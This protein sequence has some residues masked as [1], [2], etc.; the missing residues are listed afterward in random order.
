MPMRPRAEGTV[1]KIARPG[2]PRWLEASAIIV[3]LLGATAAHAQY[4]TRFSTITNGAVSFTGNTLGLSKASNLNQP[5]TQDAIGA[6]TTTNTALQVGTFPP[7]TTLA[8]AQNSSSATLNLPA[9]S[10]VLYAELTW[11]GSYGLGGQDVSGSRNNPITL[12]TPAG[13]ST[14]TPDPAF[15]RQLG[16]P[17]TGAG[18]TSNCFYV[19]T[20]NVTSLIQAGGTGTYTVGGVP[21]TVGA[22]DNTNNSAGW[23]LAVVYQDFSKPVRNLALFVGSELSGAPAASTSG[24]CTPPAGKLSGR[25]AVS[26]MEGDANKTNDTMLFGPATPLGT[27][28]QLKGPN[29]PQTNFFASQVNRDDGTLDTGGT[30]GTRNA[31][32]FTSSLTSGGRQGWDITNVDVS[33]QLR[34]GQTQAFAQGTTSGDTY[35]ISA[36]GLQIDVGAPVFPQAKSVDKATTF[37]GD[38]LTYTTTVSNTGIVDATN[39]VFTDPP[40]PGTTFIAGSFKV[41]GVVQPG[42]NPGAG[43]NLGTVAGGGSKTVQFQVR[44]N[45]IP[46]SPAPAQYDATASFTYQYVSCAGQP[47]QN[48]TFTT[49]TVTTL[50]PRIEAAKTA[51]PT[52]AVPGA[53]LEYAV[54]IQNTGTA[55]ATGVTL[56]DPIPAGTTYIPGSTTLNAVAIPDVGGMMPFALGALINDSGDPPGVI[57]AS[58]SA[59]LVFQV[60][61]DPSATM[62]ITNTATID[63]DGPGSLQPFP[64]AVISPVAAMADVTVAKDG[65]DRAVAGTNVTFTITVTNDGPSVATNVVLADPTPP[66]LGFVSNSGACT[67]AFPCALGTLAP[68]ATR[69]VTTTFSVPGTYTT[70]DPIVNLASVTS[71]TPDPATGNNAAQASV[72]VAAPV[73][74]LT[75]TKTD[76]TSSAVPGN[77]T[78]YTITVGNTG[79]SAVTGVRVTDPVTPELSGFIWTCSGSGGASCAA[80][81]GSGALD[82][83]V[84]LPVGTS[85]TFLLTAT[86]AADA[87]EAVSNT[88]TAA[89]PPGVGGTSQVAD[90]DTDQVNGLADL[91]V[92]KTGPLTAAVPGTNVVYTLVVRNAGPSTARDASVND[93]TPAGLN[94][95][96]TSGDCNTAFPC[97]FGTLLP[98]ETRTIT[99][100][101]EVPLGYTSPNPIVNTASVFDTTTDPNPGNRSTSA[102]TP[103]DLNADVAVLKSVAPTSALVGD[104]VTLFV[105]VLNNGPNQASGVVITDVLPAGMTFVSA[106]PQQGSYVPSSGQ[107]QVGDLQN[108]ANATLTMTAVLT[109][110][111]TITNTATK[112]SANEP[113]PDTSNDSAVATLNAAAAADVAIQKA[114]DN[115]TP[116][117]GQI[118][119]FVVTA[120]NNGPSNASGITVTDA[121]PA[122][123]ALVASTPSQGTYDA[124]TGAWTVG[125]IPFPGS[126]T[127]T[128]LASVNTPGMIVNTANKTQTEADPNPANDESSVSLNAGT[129]ADIRV[130]KAISNP[131]P[132]VD[133]QVTFTVTATNLGPSPATGVLITDQLPA[134]LTFVSATPSQ[135]TYDPASG[136]WTAGSIAASQSAVLSITALVAQ[137]GPFTNT[138]IKTSASEEDP[139]PGN[140]SGSVTATAGRVADLS[141]TK[142]DGLDTVVAGAMEIYTITVANAGP[143]TVTGASVSDTFPV[144]LTGVTWTCSATDGG[145]CGTASGDGPIATTV[146]LPAGAAAIFT[147]TV[148]V[149]PDAIGALANSASVTPPAGTTDPTPGD[150]T[151]TDTT[152]ITPSADVQVSKTAS[153]GSV[154]AGDDITFT[155]VVTNIGPS[156]AV[157]VVV[158]DPTPTGLTFTSNGDACTTVFPCTLG[159]LAPGASATI[160]SLFHIPGNYAGP[161]PIENTATASSATPDPVPAN[162]AGSASASLSDRQATLTVTK[163]DGTASVVP[164]NPT[165]YTITVTNSGPSDASGVSVQDQVTVLS[166]A[167]WTCSATGGGSCTTPTG[168]GSIDTTVN[169]PANTAATFVLTGTVPADATGTLTNTAEAMPPAGFANPGSGVATDTDELTPQADLALTKSGPPTVVPGN[170]AVYTIVV[171]NEGPSTATN[172]VVNDSTP[173]GLTFVSNSGDCTTPFPCTLATL[174]PRASRTITTTLLVPP[175]YQTPNPI[176]Q[177]A[178]V[179][180]QTPD[181]VPGNDSASVQ[182]PVDANADVEVTK[183]VAPATGILVGDSVSFT[184]QARNNGPNAATGVVVTDL[185]PAGLS[186]VSASPTQGAYTDSSGEWVISAL[187]AGQSVEL[188]IQAQ[189]TQPGDITNLAIRTGGNEPDPNPGNE[190]GAATINVAAAADVAVQKTADKTTPSVGE[191]VTF[192]VTATNR[193]PSDAT[194]V[195][196]QDALPAGLALTS[197]A[198]SQGTYDAASGIWTVG[199]LTASTS[200]T[201][202]VV[203]SVNTTGTLVNVA[204]KTGQTEI[205]PNP[206]NDQA[207]LSLNAAATADIDVGKTI[208]TASPAVGGQVSFTVTAT[209]HGPSPATGVVVTDLLP[210]G[211]A[212]VSAPASQGTYD[213]DSGTWTVGNLPATRSAILSITARV[214]R[215]GSFTNTASR[216]AGN[217]ID[218]NP[219]NDASSVPGT[220]ALVADL[221]ITKTDGQT[222]ALPGAPLTYT[223]TVQNAG[224]SDVAGAPVG[225]TFPGPLTGASWS[226]SATPG[227][228]CGTPGGTGA[229]ATTVDLPAGGG[230]TFIATATVP[231]D[232][233]GAVTNTA[234]V[235]APTGTVDPD[236]T[237]DDATDSTDLTSSAN[238]GVTKAGPASAFPGERVSYT[239]VVSNAGASTA[240]DVV[241]TDPTPPGLAF[242]SNGGDC[243]T[244]FP[245]ALG[246]IAPSGSRTIVATYTVLPEATEVVNSATV[247]S[248]TPDPDASD[249]TGSVTTEVGLVS[250]PP[251]TDADLEVSKTGTPTSAASGTQV[252]Y[253]LRVVNHGP[254]SASNVLLTDTLPAGVQLVSATASAGACTGGN[255]I[256]CTVASLASGGTLT[257]T[258]VVRVLPSASGALVDTATV[259]SDQPDPVATNN[260]ATAQTTVPAQADLHL[261]KSVS[262]AQPR[263]GEAL[264]YTLTVTNAGPAKATNV[265]VVDPLPS[266]VT[267]GT[268][269]PSQGTCTTAVQVVTCV[270]GDLASGATA[271]VA[272]V[273]TRAND[274]A[275]SN[276]ATVTAT[277]PDPNPSDDT[278]TVATPGLTPEDCGNCIDDDQNGLVDAEDPACCTAQSLTFTQARFRPGKSTLRAT[279]TLAPGA[280][281]GVDPRAQDVRVQIRADSGE[282]VCC[283]I[284]TQQ[285]QKLFHQTYGFFDQ[286]MTLCP[287]IKCVRLVV[288]RT[289]PAKA[290][291]ILGRMKPGSPLLSPVEITIDTGSQCAAGRLSLQPKGKHGAGLP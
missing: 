198:P 113:D 4:V 244:A 287:P 132:A 37:V 54:A 202:T 155:T 170:A 154:T 218:P 266:A 60:V 272:I 163:D 217:E 36:L 145:A 85:A 173:S 127:L 86:I 215:L 93:P 130:T 278:A 66:G 28:N 104:T 289:G 285:W 100:T 223:I 160:T 114:V 247:A 270:L 32:A 290:T 144:V 56:T 35:V 158:D 222:L 282:Q 61:V 51:S 68:G 210:P 120:T 67:T 216:T 46:A 195:E 209:N 240:T 204:R 281:A 5:G 48:G 31:N 252:T 117:V 235:R 231:P 185:L 128:V 83:T 251:P 260:G 194:G 255:P 135:G 23:T 108:G 196:V 15:Q 199:D 63:A 42:A 109:Q 96:S 256:T 88:A 87:R 174:A 180:S 99:A 129:T 238:L 169:L 53:P 275:F 283:T 197:A 228:S 190:S 265:T 41:D 227:G 30:F 52:P 243:M 181:P 288:P 164:G 13:T 121:L 24:F 149:T 148:T 6:F 143:S 219:A 166:G 226:C 62:P 239:I 119:T 156:T 1:G 249:D 136:A 263:N 82:T 273:G 126:A 29:N 105:S 151:A 147:A 21:A 152:A 167:T 182:T 79:P 208:S 133:Q 280:F 267:P 77:T 18:C 50:V 274:N 64:A 250:P 264:S 69:T 157:G 125:A 183:S 103:V 90:T 258:I 9:N 286:R 134:E 118:V 241:V 172:V 213:E 262:P 45:S 254:A 112:T 242:V 245:C 176:V 175:G 74:N 40:P 268:L 110:A 3:M 16:S 140:D 14:V 65:P 12:T 150:D 107:W 236:P 201:L 44:V 192:T 206:L 214:T 39:V 221:S 111:G 7:G 233:T 261:T 246:T 271:T 178:S 78:T 232:A 237:S 59:S 8:F 43:V 98:G 75:I 25:L 71:D 137:P 115:P 184:I 72:S 189:V 171:T 122:G 277:E 161:D 276:T 80:G 177:T 95:V 153:S 2:R 97:E 188:T 116:S 279:A 27:T 17:N 230:A 11:G 191:S 49:N 146:D 22:S 186:F 284:G 19:R 224:P 81:S 220:T 162:N 92:V 234:S 205:D 269:T 168:A 139:N 73:A 138:A 10:T 76:G 94:F 26:A 55:A 225:D 207:S 165:T 124:A 70:P 291:V 91:S 102:Q 248:S 101:F 159:T 141:V 211:F 84:N 200:A 58:R 47:T 212:V 20:A 179:S 34:N 203:A 193:G 123:L 257:A 33:A 229:I 187:A 142:T 259:R 253:T 131:T 38:T 57:A 89:N 106:S